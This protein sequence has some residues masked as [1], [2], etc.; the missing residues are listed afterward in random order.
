[1]T[2]VGTTDPH[3]QQAPRIGR[4]AGC[5][6]G[7]AG[8]RPSTHAEIILIEPP[9][10]LVY[11]WTSSEPAPTFVEYDLAEDKPYTRLRF[12]NHPFHAGPD[13]NR[14]DDANFAGWLGFAV[15]MK[16]LVEQGAMP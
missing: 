10:R 1:V 7:T 9:R 5:L 8:Q 6:R 3:H 15:R 12:R 14:F 2:A 4:T 16:Q 13:W 11:R